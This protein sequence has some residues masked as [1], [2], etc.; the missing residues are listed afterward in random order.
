VGAPGENGAKGATAASTATTTT[1]RRTCTVEMESRSG[2]GAFSFNMILL[3]AGK[4][5]MV[6]QEVSVKSLNGDVKPL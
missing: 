6:V 1:K 4:E 2:V 5:V 3:S